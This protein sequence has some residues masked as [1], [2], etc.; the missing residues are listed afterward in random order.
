MVAMATPS[1]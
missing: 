1:N